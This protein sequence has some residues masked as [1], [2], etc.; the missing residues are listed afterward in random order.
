MPKVVSQIECNNCGD[1]FTAT[2]S[3]DFT[4]CKCGKCGVKPEVYGTTYKRESS[5]KV[6]KSEVFYSDDDFNIL[7]SE[8]SD[9]W[10]KIKLLETEFK[11]N[12]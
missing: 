7:D 1:K 10:N 8:S 5:F 12:Y 6:L 3:E 4:Y 11:F 2:T 9:L